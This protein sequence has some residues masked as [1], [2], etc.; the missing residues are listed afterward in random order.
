[1]SYK[2]K[3]KLTGEN[4]NVFNL[5]S[6]AKKALIKEKLADKAKEMSKR[7]IM[8]R[9]YDDALTIIQEYVDIE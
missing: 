5:I 9:S 1:M 3:C 7:A 8:A 4:G 6:L 2:P